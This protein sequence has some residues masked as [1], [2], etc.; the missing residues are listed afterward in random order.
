MLQRPESV[1]RPV[2]LPPLRHPYFQTSRDEQREAFVR[3]VEESV[4][5]SEALRAR[6]KTVRVLE[7]VQ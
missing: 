1:R 7:T 6:L 5:R 2:E 4:R 3:E